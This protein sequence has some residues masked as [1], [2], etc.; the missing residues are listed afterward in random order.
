MQSNE[1][2]WPFGSG[3]L[4]TKTITSCKNWKFYITKQ[5]FSQYCIYFVIIKQ[6]LYNKVYGNKMS[7]SG[8]NNDLFLLMRDKIMDKN[9]A[10]DK[11]V[12]LLNNIQFLYENISTSVYWYK[13]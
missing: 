7:I 11:E 6:H 13:V 5:W 1:N 8:M 2:T 3:E 10:Q 4:K 9:S 12:I